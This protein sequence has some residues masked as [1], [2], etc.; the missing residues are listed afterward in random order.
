MKKSTTKNT[1]IKRTDPIFLRCTVGKGIKFTPMYVH[2]NNS[3]DGL[4]YIIELLKRNNDTG[5][6]EI[7]NSDKFNLQEKE[8]SELFDFITATTELKTKD[9]VSLLDTDEKQ[10][11]VLHTL[12]QNGSLI[13]LLQSGYL[14]ESDYNALKAT[15]RF[16]D[17]ENSVA[18]LEYLLSNSDKEKDYEKW[19]KDNIWAF[20]N[21]YV[22][23]DNIHQISNAERVDL[24]VRNTI[25][26]YRDIIEFKKP[27][28]NVL[29]YDDS[30][31]NY[32]FTK[33]VSKAI[34]QAIN[35]SDIFMMAASDGLHKHKEIKGYYPKSIIVIGRSNNFN[36]EQI[37][38]LR[39]LNGRLSNIEIKTYDD[40]LS[41]AKNLI[42]TISNFNFL[43]KDLLQK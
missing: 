30:H 20:G 28:L 38:A 7:I 13:K 1:N 40:L 27:S 24:L 23:S 34:S 36:D 9:A 14:N 22:A 33:E 31:S 32:Y 17:L 11:A 43:Q 8:I 26:C 41:Q 18:R 25:N 15:I 4:Y 35:Y 42:A 37:C 39:A 3:C 5:A 21:Y 2:H 12:L 16:S 6:W 19:C 10:S 29:E